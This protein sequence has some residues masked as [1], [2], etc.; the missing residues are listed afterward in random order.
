MTSQRLLLA[1]ALA[2]VVPAAAAEAQPF[3]Y[4]PAPPYQ[5]S[6]TPPSWSYD[7]YTSGQAPCPQGIPGDL[8]RCREKMPP[9]V[10]QPDY[11]SR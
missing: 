6:A 1:A 2:A 10:G 4:Q 5:A 7:P 3:Y 9:S 8:Q 11:W